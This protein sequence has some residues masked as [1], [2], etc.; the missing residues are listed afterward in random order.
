[1]SDTDSVSNTNLEQI[2]VWVNHGVA[3]VWLHV[4]HSLSLD[5]Q[6]ISD[7]HVAVD[8]WQACLQPYKVLINTLLQTWRRGIQEYKP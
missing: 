6:T 5:L 2:D 3:E 4:G 8:L 1:M 7:P